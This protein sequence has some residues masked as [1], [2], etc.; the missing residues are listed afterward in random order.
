MD[1]ISH[2]TEETVTETV[3][4]PGVAVI[5]FWAGWCG[6]C[7][8]MAAQFEKAARLRPEYRFAKVDVDA[9]PGLPRRF[10]VR[11]IPTVMVVRD[12]EP[13]A[14]QAGVI[15]AEQLIEALDRVAATT[16]KAAA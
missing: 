16:A 2:L 8:A 5:D 7:R 15:G 4:Q 1:T 12:G 6:P 3:E 14:V 13:V 10:G 11:S 9:E